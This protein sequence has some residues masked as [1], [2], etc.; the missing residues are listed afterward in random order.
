MTPYAHAVPHRRRYAAFTRT[1]LEVL[2]EVAHAA[3]LEA[4]SVTASDASLNDEQR[5]HLAT[6]TRVAVIAGNAA[7]PLGLDRDS[8]CAVL[9]IDAMTDA[10]CAVAAAHAS[11]LSSAAAPG[12]GADATRT[13]LQ[14]L[15]PYV[16]ASWPFYMAALSCGHHV[17][18]RRALERLPLIAEAGGGDF[19]RQRFASDLWPPL[20]RL[21]LHGALQTH[22]LVDAASGT[23]V[24]MQHA[25]LTCLLEIAGNEQSRDAFADVVAD[26]AEALAT[27]I[28]SPSG[29]ELQGRAEELLHALGSL[30]ADAV[31]LVL[32]KLRRVQ[33]PPCAALPSL[34][35]C[36]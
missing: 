2:G 23:V 7:A 5:R 28:R 24:R 22:Q 26:A 19:I 13:E 25:A 6:V 36:C 15:L 14:P 31:W 11:P 12:E 27:V 34:L 8:L 32:F 30:D 20:R 10:V 9:A 4:L 29:A 17:A 33:P 3:H 1:F 35:A 18:V 16:H 21:L